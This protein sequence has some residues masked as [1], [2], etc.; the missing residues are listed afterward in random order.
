LHCPVAR[1]YRYCCA[2]LAAVTSPAVAAQTAWIDT[3]EV[4]GC[5]GNWYWIERPYSMRQCLENGKAL[6]W[7]LE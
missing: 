2:A 1:T 3:A 7:P 4:K 5:D 6:H